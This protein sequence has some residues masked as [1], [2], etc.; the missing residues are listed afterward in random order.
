MSW[1]IQITRSKPNPAGKD[2]SNGM[3][4]PS[5]LL[6]E[7]ADLKNIGD[8]AINLAVLNLAHSEFHH[9]CSLKEEAQIYWTGSASVALRPGE[10]VRVHTGRSA[11]AWQMTMEDRS[12]VNHHSFAESGS[13]VLNNDCGDNLT[14]WWRGQ[15][16]K[17]HREDKASYGPNP[18][19][20]KILYRVGDRLV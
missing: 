8:S 4:I 17:W 10:M 11:D 13:F 9:G 2:K 5:Q 1:Q 6:G 18:H 3:A 12:G 19:D 16:G 14:L 15:D 7:W 20:G